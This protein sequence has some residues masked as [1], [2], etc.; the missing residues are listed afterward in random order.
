MQLEPTSERMIE[1]FY[2][3]SPEN[4]LI[5]LFHIAT[6]DFALPFIEGGRVLDY[7]CGSG[8]GT[9]R[10]AAACN[11]II[12][13]DIAQEAIDFARSRY[14]APN[15]SFDKIQP[16]DQ[17]PLPYDSA[18]FDAVLSFQVIEHIRDAGPYLSEIARVLKPGGVF[19]CA[20]PDRSTRL[21]S[22]QKPWNI[23]HVHEYDETDLRNALSIRFSD[24]KIFKMGG[25]DAIDIEIRRTRKLKWITLPLTLSFMPESVR[26]GGLSFLKYISGQSKRAPSS[27]AVQF[28][29]SQ[30]DI[31]ISECA[32]P[33]VNL[34]AVSLKQ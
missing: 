17:A 30:S 33:S 12:G 11:Q 10:V 22:R 19:L 7:G 21:F 25:T 34:I 3:S 4:Y 27:H 23:W 14:S 8:Y 16:V 32:S 9:H 13:V 28:G 26:I 20:T 18:S 2:L 29:F 6:Y 1:E 5:Y 24:I 15:L 31:T